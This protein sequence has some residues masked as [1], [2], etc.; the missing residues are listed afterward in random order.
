M[1]DTEN[2]SQYITTPV[3]SM[4]AA[5]FK[6][7]YSKIM[8]VTLQSIVLQTSQEIN[9]LFYEIYEVTFLSCDQMVDFEP[10]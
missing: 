4:Q 7:Y 8:R 9:V 3:N 10:F 1:A 2:I 5:E 6:T